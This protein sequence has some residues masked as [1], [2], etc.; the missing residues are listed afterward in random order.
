MANWLACRNV[1]FKLLNK[2]DSID[3]NL[4]VLKNILMKY[5]FLIEKNAIF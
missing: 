2:Q 5:E 3:Q 1:Q 4:D